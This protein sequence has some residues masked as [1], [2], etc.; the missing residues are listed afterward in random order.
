[1]IEVIGALGRLFNTLGYRLR[2][3]L[4]EWRKVNVMLREYSWPWYQKVLIGVG[5]HP[6]QYPLELLFV[7]LAL[8]AALWGYHALSALVSAEPQPRRIGVEQHFFT[9]LGLRRARLL[10]LPSVPGELF[11]TKVGLCRMDGDDTQM[12]ISGK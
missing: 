8:S 6:I 10:I 11:E 5:E 2:C 3:E 4:R 12:G 1:L 9:F 7:V